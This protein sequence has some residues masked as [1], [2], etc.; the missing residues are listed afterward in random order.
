MCGM[1]AANPDLPQL[2][3]QDNGNGIS[4][5]K[6]TDSSSALDAGHGEPIHNYRGWKAMPYVIGE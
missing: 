1:D 5:E 4:I 6:T 3:Q 2:E